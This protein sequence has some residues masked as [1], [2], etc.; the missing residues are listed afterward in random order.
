MPES[1]KEKDLVYKLEHITGVEAWVSAGENE[2]G[3]KRIEEMLIQ[4]SFY[5]GAKESLL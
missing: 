5:V 3:I 2:V 1:V 4:D